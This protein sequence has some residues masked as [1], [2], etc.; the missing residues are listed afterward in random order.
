[1]KNTVARQVCE[2]VHNRVECM[3]MACQGCKHAPMEH[4]VDM[5]NSSEL[6]DRENKMTKWDVWT[7][8]MTLLY[9][10]EVDRASRRGHTQSTPSKAGMYVPIGQTT[11]HM[12]EDVTNPTARAQPSHN[13]DVKDTVM[14][15]QGPITQVIVD[16]S[17]DPIDFATLNR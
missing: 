10:P 2:E 8:A 12:N 9:L 3:D 6:L 11:E 13:D 4:R 17:R 14:A 15:G 7:G 5:V 16:A 1:M